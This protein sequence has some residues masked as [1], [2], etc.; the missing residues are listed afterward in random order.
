MNTTQEIPQQMNKNKVNLL[1][2][3]EETKERVKEKS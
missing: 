2:R 3:K 1:E